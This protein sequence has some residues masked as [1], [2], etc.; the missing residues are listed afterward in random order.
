ML[1]MDARG[2]IGFGCYALVIVVMM[3]IWLDKSLLKDDFF[4]LIATAIVLTAWINGPVGWAYQATKSGT[5][6]AASSARIAESAAGVPSPPT[7]PTE[8]AEVMVVNEPDAPVP[9]TTGDA[10]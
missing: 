3:M 10:P 7:P 6:A 8:P 1:K 9:T 5:E 4:K 2:W